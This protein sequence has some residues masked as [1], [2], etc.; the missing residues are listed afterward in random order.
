M[1]NTDNFIVTPRA[2]YPALVSGGKI[3]GQ[4][5]AT[6]LINGLLFAA[7]SIDINQ[8]TNNV[9]NGSIISG[10]NIDMK[11]GLGWLVTYD[12]DLVSDPPPYFTAG[13]GSASGDGWKEI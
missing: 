9:I 11:D 10:G 4:K 1:T 7:T 3:T 12:S 6:S 13:S 2:N 8:A 5:L